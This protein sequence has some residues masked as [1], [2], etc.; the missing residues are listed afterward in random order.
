MARWKLLDNWE[1]DLRGL[2]EQQ[3]AERLALANQRESESL[4]K[5]AGRNPKAAREWRV[6][7]QQVEDELARRA[8]SA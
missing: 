1:R 5:G 6:R 8:A 2:S 3:L 7:A 4:R